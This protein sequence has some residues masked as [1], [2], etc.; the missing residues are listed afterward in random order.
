MN[1]KASV[2]QCINGIKTT[3]YTRRWKALFEPLSLACL[4]IRMR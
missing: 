3:V 2:Q 1:K 4:A